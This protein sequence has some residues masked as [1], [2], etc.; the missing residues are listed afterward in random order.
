MAELRLSEST[1]ER[2]TEAAG[3][4]VDEAFFAFRKTQKRQK[5]SFLAFQESAAPCHREFFVGQ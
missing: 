3:G 2:A 4:R 5:L 1:V